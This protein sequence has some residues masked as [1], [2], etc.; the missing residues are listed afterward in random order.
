M[1]FVPEIVSKFCHDMENQTVVFSLTPAVGLNNM[2]K[3][4][5]HTVLKVLNHWVAETPIYLVKYPI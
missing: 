4:F 5:N 1:D 3:T 2:D